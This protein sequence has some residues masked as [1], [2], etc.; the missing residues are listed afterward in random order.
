M[1]KYFY[2]IYDKYNKKIVALTI[3]TEDKTGY[4]PDRFEYD[5]HGTKL[6]YQYNVYKVLEQNEKK[7]LDSDNPF[8]LV[9]LAGLYTLQTKGEENLRYNFKRKLF[10]LLLERGHD[11]EKIYKIFEFLDGILFLPSNLELKFRDDVIKS[12][13]GDKMGVS[14]EMTNLYQAGKSKGKKEGKAEGKIE[15]KKEG[16]IEMVE[17][18]LKVG[19][20][21]DKI[22]EA[23]GLSEEEIKKIKKKTR[24]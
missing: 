12:I 10:K 3:F 8:A 7:L 9:I 16:M 4:K 2:R 5:F 20:E 1:F 24:H 6:D 17:N 13:G 18:L 23:S 11:K 19:V 15:G 14:K 21:V 22:I